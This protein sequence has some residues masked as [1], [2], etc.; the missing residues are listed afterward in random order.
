MTGTWHITEMEMWDEDYINLEQQA[1]IRIR[2][3]GGG[4]Y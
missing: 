3:S 2:E 1:Y 4:V